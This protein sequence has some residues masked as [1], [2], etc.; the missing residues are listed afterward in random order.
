MRWGCMLINMDVSKEEGK[1]FYKF[2]LTILLKAIFV[3]ERNSADNLSFI[4]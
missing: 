2:F 1:I 4:N 3:A